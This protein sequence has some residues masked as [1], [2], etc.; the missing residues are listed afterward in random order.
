MTPERW[1]RLQDIFHRASELDPDRQADFVKVSCDGDEELCEEALSLIRSGS[2]TGH[3]N[4]FIQDAIGETAKDAVS[5]ASGQVR[6]KRIG[7]YEVIDTLGHGGMG[8]VYLA[9]RADK[10]FQQRVAIKLVRGGLLDPDIAIRLRS[11]RQILASLEHPNIARLLDGGATEDGIPYLVIE[12]IKGR[13]INEYCDD[14]RLGIEERLE[15]FRTVCSAV[16]HAHRNLIVHRDLKPSNILVTPEGVP[17]LL[18]F[19]IAKILDASRTPHTVAV[20]QADLR[21]MTPEHASPEQ[22]R[23]EAI[24]TATDTYALG[25]LLYELLTGYRPFRVSGARMRQ[26]EQIICETDPT[27]PSV[28]AHKGTSIDEKEDKRQFRVRPDITSRLRNSTPE[29]L[30]G[31]F[32]GDLDNIVL[33]ALRKEPERRYASVEQ[34]SEDIKRYLDDLPIVACADTW[35]YRSQKFVRRHAVGVAMAAVFVLL[36]VNFGIYMSVQRN[37]AVRLQQ[38]AEEATLI[39]EQKGKTSEQVSAFL[40]DLFWA[41]DPSQ[42]QGEELSA[43][44]LLDEGVKKIDQLQD[45]PDIMAVLK[46]TMGRA[47]HGLGELQTARQLLSDAL[48]IRQAT[49]NQGDDQLLVKE[50]LINLAAVLNEDAQ[51]VEARDLLHEAIRINVPTPEGRHQN[52]RALAELGDVV[53]ANGRYAEAEA[54]YLKARNIFADLLADES[55]DQG[56]ISEEIAEVI[57]QQAQA[58]QTMGDLSRAEILFREALR[59]AED[60]LGSHHPQTIDYLH[61]LAV[62]LQQQRKLSDA[63]PLFVK[64]I[65]LFRSVNGPDHHD[66]SVAM[67]NYGR[68]LYQKRDYERAEEV[69]EEALTLSIRI[70]GED[71]PDVGFHKQN[72][73]RLYGDIGDFR[74][75]ERYLTE[76][77]EFYKNKFGNVHARVASALVDL[78]EAEI[79]RNESATAEPLLREALEI[80]ASV[81]PEDHW[82]GFHTRSL[83]GQ[84][85]TDQGR[86]E[87]AEPLLLGSYSALRETFGHSDRRSADS[88]GRLVKLYEKWDRPEK[89]A[90]YQDLMETPLSAAPQ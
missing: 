56:E 79:K 85:L 15:L 68:L 81:L 83:L 13:P 77:V 82:F 20:T 36:L 21:L 63:E 41:T 34:F 54:H 16:H 66:L 80:E 35:A 23:G 60:Q 2:E 5:S 86:Y 47:Y 51:Y 71:H 87:E 4:D 90:E 11:E 57:N 17:K 48:E 52:A 14:E 59:S 12:Y 6:G 69:L 10:Q 42:A 62:I 24:T 38:R 32:V 78:G 19:G 9:E 25:V 74:Q 89:A 64:A 27:P 31:K 26:M 39:A 43:K 45:Q 40:V 88:I 67:G 70:R 46:D 33:M 28:M 65:D 55:Q 7:A 73:G 30:R 72:L 58:A 75:A 53:S 1:A 49:L 18:D 50:S 61:N 3:T 22:V 84:A 44:D 8:V 29:K 37:E 76:A